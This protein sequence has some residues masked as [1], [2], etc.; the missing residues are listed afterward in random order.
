MNA[1]EKK[2]NEITPADLDGLL[3]R[4]ENQHLDFKATLGDTPKYEIAKDI[5]C[6][7]NS[8]GGLI[9]VGAVEDSATTKCIS[10]S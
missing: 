9:V 2:L 5:A 4:E 3:G 10:F 1:E 8:G 6:F 7:A